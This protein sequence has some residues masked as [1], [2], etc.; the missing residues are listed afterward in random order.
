MANDWFMGQLMPMFIVAELV[1]YGDEFIFWVSARCLTSIVNGKSHAVELVND[2]MPE[3]QAEDAYVPL[4]WDDVVIDTVCVRWPICQSSAT[5]KA[6]QY[7]WGL[8]DQLGPLV[9]TIFFD[10]SPII[11]AAATSA[12]ELH[13]NRL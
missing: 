2:I 8:M 7:V 6:L 9:E 4:T 12:A 3:I 5:L 11:L 13:E 1:V 10:M